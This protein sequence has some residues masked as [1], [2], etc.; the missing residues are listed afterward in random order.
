MVAAG[1]ALLIGLLAGSRAAQPPDS[2]LANLPL[3]EIPAMDSGRV[4]MVLHISGD[5]GWGVTDRELSRR[6][7]ERGIPVVGLNSLRYFWKARTPDETARDV[8]RILRR[9]LAVWRRTEIILVGYSFGADV[10]PFVAT[11][12]PDDLRRRIEAVALL[13]PDAKADFQ[14][15]ITSWLGSSSSKAFPVPPEIEKLRGMRILCIQGR[16][17]GSAV[18]HQLP[19]DLVTAI[20]I[21]G[22]HRIGGNVEEIAAAILGALP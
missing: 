3:V 13:G 18:C 1:L 20:D 4:E 5:G 21:S 15:H 12:L 11:R 22:H 10:M 17:D 2:T 9:Y 7:A 8:E 19:S 14:F 6:L 16:E